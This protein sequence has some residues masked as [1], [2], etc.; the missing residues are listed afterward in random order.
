MTEDE[1]KSSYELETANVII[2]RFSKLD[3]DQV[4]AVL[5][6]GHGPFV[7]G[8]SGKN[9]IENAVALELV[10]EMALKTIQLNSK[11][12]P[13]DQYL[14]DKHFFRKHGK[15]AYYGQS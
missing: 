5:V 13:I 3:P 12:Q 11:I 9:A 4:R 15:N 8:S 2:E 14:L 10:A 7:W 6:H 1:I